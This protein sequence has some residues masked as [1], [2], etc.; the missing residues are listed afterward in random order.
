MPRLIA[1]TD[2]NAQDLLVLR[3]LVR[4]GVLAADQ[5]ARRYG[6]ASLAALRIPLLHDGRAILMWRDT[7]DGER[8]YS[9]TALGRHLA[10]VEVDPLKT[11]ERHLAHDVAVVDLAD[12]LLAHNPGL[13]WRTE[14]ELRR[15]LD[16]IALPPAYLPGDNRHRPDG[17]LFEHGDRVAVELEHSDKFEQ[18]YTHISRWFAREY[19]LDRVRWY[20]DRPRI[21]RRL[22]AINH[23]FGF[24]RDIPIEI[25]P[26]PPGVVIRKRPDRFER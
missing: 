24:A 17:L 11:N 16:A 2:L 5:I 6:D 23:D 10:D 14:R 22:Q 8:V 15:V 13:E 9:A 4:F 21:V 19:R 20:V 1:P 18:R 7:L 25:E 3:D 12:Y 26:F